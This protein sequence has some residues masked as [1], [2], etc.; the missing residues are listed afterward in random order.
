MIKSVGQM[1]L[2]LDGALDTKPDAFNDWAHDF[3]PDMVNKSRGGRD[4]TG[5]TDREVDKVNELW[6]EHYA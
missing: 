3:I 5:L 2:D 4:T 6:H 1:L